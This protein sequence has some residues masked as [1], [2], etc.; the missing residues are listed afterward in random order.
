MW[1]A[2]LPNSYIIALLN[3][4]FTSRVPI[5]VDSKNDGGKLV[6]WVST[7]HLLRFNNNYSERNSVK[8]E[9]IGLILFLFSNY[10]STFTIPM[11]SFIHT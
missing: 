3:L 10:F 8:P 6:F 9:I 11:F 2:E 5:K 1:S 7:L 4:E